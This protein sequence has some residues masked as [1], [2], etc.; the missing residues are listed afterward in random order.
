[1][2]ALRGTA[3]LLKIVNHNFFTNAFENFFDEINVERVHLVIVL[4]LLAGENQIQRNLIGL[5]HHRAMAAGHLADVKMQH[6]WD[7]FEILIRAGE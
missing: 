6:A 7:R 4:R 2:P 1:M 5:I 3:A